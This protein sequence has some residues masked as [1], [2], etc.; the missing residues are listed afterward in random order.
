LYFHEFGKEELNSLPQL[1]KNTFEFPYIPYSY[2]T[3]YEGKF[4]FRV[5]DFTYECFKTNIEQ[6]NLDEINLSDFTGVLVFLEKR[7]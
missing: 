4:D 2:F 7:K 5:A 3:F 1:N 6:P